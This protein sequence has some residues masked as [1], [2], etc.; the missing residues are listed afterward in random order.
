MHT[1]AAHATS[2]SPLS[3]FTVCDFFLWVCC[4]RGWG[5]SSHNVTFSSV[6]PQMARTEVWWV[7]VG[8]ARVA[9]C[10]PMST[11]MHQTSV[12]HTTVVQPYVRATPTHRYTRP[13]RSFMC[14]L[15][16]ARV[17]RCPDMSTR[18]H[19]TSVWHTTVVGSS[20]AGVLVTA[21]KGSLSRFGARGTT[22]RRHGRLE[23]RDSARPHGQHL[24][25]CGRA[26]VSTWRARP[27]PGG[28][29]RAADGHRPAR[30]G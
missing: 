2:R 4:R 13:D 6:R 19:Q 22:G 28:L 18:M 26:V 23:R 17:A 27:E 29:P 5:T 16:V 8:V 14:S 15:G 1:T 10:P 7:G 24:W 30:R 3:A 21:T 9:R 25:P 11:R 12:W 20:T